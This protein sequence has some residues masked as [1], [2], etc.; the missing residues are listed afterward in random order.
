MLLLVGPVTP[1]LPW[2][3]PLK[4]V[5][6]LTALALTPPSFAAILLGSVLVLRTPDLGRVADLIPSTEVSVLM[7]ALALLPI[8]FGCWS[9]IADMWDVCRVPPSLGVRS[10]DIK[11][12]SSRG[13][14]A[15]LALALCVRRPSA[16]LFGGL[17]LLSVSCQGAEAVHLFRVDRSP[18]GRAPTAHLCEMPCPAHLRIHDRPTPCR[19]RLP[20]PIRAADGSFVGTSFGV[21][22]NPVA[23]AE[24][25]R[26][27]LF[28][29]VTL[30]SECARS[31][32]DWAFLAVTLLETL[33]EFFGAR[34][35]TGT[36]NAPDAPLPVRPQT[37]ALDLLVPLQPMPLAPTQSTKA[38][39]F[40]LD[41]R[42]CQLP[43]SVSDV[44]VLFS[45]ASF[46]D[47]PDTPQGLARPE[48]FARW[49]Q[50]GLVGRSPAP[51]E[52]LVFTSD[53][54][55]SDGVQAAGWG[56]TVSLVCTQSLRLPGQYIGSFGGSMNDFCAA[57]PAGTLLLDPYMAEVAGL[58]WAGIA[59]AKL[60]WHGAVL[61]RA[62]NTSALAGVQ[63]TANMPDHPVCL[64]AR[65]LHTALQ[66][67]AR[68]SPSYQHVPGHAGDEAN[69][70]ADAVAGLAS[71]SPGT[72][73]PFRFDLAFWC[74]G[75][76]HRSL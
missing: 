52:I 43:C 74:S 42:Q 10:A 38:E 34:L 20:P 54:S 6:P 66:L 61:F 9:W 16:I 39:V 37:L 25:I 67:G 23:D 50:D 49:R 58:L 26:P 68:C 47:L 64:L 59:A 73:P 24:D 5:S 29:T 71:I 62:D 17:L 45:G 76:G 31:S 12:N 63:G 72:R 55:Y 48:R 22:A 57:V 30:L 44:K 60:P 51:D 21:E 11:C 70:L 69:E 19:G 13:V 32:Q 1:L 65:Y 27:Y 41:A 4:T 53:G 75:N 28:D 3:L 36:V 35:Q 40:D 7:A 33:I 8:L 15:C 46:A 14:V 18:A 2:S 56:V